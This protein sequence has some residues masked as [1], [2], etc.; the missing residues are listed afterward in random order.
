M[1]GFVGQQNCSRTPA[2]IE[3]FATGGLGGLVRGDLGDLHVL[4]ESVA[5]TYAARSPTILS[6]DDRISRAS[7]S[8]GGVGDHGRCRGGGSGA[9]KTILS[10]DSKPEHPSVGAAR[11]RDQVCLRDKSLAVTT[12]HRLVVL[13]VPSAR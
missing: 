6:I 5:R 7:D 13:V 11:H 3:D 1:R 2:G 4:L 9:T 12:L 10:S 8:S